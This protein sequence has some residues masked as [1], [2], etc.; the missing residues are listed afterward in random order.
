M[1][2]GWTTGSP[3]SGRLVAV[4]RSVLLGRVLTSSCS[5]VMGVGMAAMAFAMS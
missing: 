5:I 3:A 2:A 1:A 4:M